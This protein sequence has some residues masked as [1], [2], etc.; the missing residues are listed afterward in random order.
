MIYIRSIKASNKI[1]L[2]IPRIFLAERNT[3]VGKLNIRAYLPRPALHIRNQI[4]IRCSKQNGFGIAFDSS[5][6]KCFLKS[7][8]NSFTRIISACNN[9]SL[10]NKNRPESCYEKLPWQIVF[11]C[12]DKIAQRFN[13]FL[14][15]LSQN[16]L[17][18]E[19]HRQK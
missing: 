13:S 4:I 7:F 16:H 10:N 6:K 8:L 17:L 14:H 18:K 11:G 5:I 12:L 2:N 3:C 19:N 1:Y 15:A 9:I